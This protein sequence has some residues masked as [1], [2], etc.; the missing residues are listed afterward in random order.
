LT[1]SLGPFYFVFLQNGENLP[2][3]NAA[4][5][6]NSLIIAKMVKVLESD[7]FA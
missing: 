4:F 3:T 2:K 6:E 5:F 7:A 1:I